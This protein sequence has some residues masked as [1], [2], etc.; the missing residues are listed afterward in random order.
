MTTQQVCAECHQL[1]VC[2]L[3]LSETR[4]PATP[5]PKRREGSKEKACH[6][7]RQ[8][9]PSVLQSRPLASK[10]VGKT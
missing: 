7:A 6:T 10:R 4:E 3:Q 1:P 2:R 9:L 5:G 8:E